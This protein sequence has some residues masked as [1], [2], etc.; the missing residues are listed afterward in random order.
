MVKSKNIDEQIL[1]KLEQILRVLSIQVAADKSF[2]ERAKLLKMA[3][4]D[5]QAIADVLNISIASVRTLTSNLRVKV[6]G[7]RKR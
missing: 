1:H 2:T 7:R 3:G 6:G 4:L 5:N